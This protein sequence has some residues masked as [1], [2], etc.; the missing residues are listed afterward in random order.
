MTVTGREAEPRETFYLSFLNLFQ[1]WES[2]CQQAKFQPN[3]QYLI[4]H[5]IIV[6]SAKII[7]D[8]LEINSS[9]SSLNFRYTASN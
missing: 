5:N 8:S 1:S 7:E 3:N 6:F 2:L 9:N 4:R